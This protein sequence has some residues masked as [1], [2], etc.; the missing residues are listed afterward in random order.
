MRC[1]KVSYLRGW[2]KERGAK[3]HG[4]VVH[5][6]AHMCAL[7]SS[8]TLA[9]LAAL[10]LLAGASFVTCYAATV[11]STRAERREPTLHLQSQAS[12]PSVLIAAQ[13]PVLRTEGCFFHFHSWPFCF[14][15]S[16]ASWALAALFQPDHGRQCSPLFPPVL[17]ASYSICMVGAL[18]VLS[19]AN[20]V[21]GTFETLDT[22]QSVCIQSP[23][24]WQ[25]LAFC[26]RVSIG[27]S[28]TWC[29]GIV[30]R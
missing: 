29:Y 7:V 18:D 4:P 23:A 28:P 20:A 22:W 8:C 30:L 21:T 15:D 17:L 24:G 1:F 10:C 19:L 5:T 16:K 25:P 26:K 3:R 11:D 27:A 13:D 12:Q 9:C 14:H 2:C 6:S